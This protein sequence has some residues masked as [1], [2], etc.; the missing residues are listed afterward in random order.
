[1]IWINTTKE[2]CD[3]GIPTIPNQFTSL[4]KYGSFRSLTVTDSPREP[5][6]RVSQH[7]F[8][9]RTG[10][11]VA[12]AFTGSLHNISLLDLLLCPNTSHMVWV[13]CG[14]RVSQLSV[15]ILMSY[16]PASLSWQPRAGSDGRTN[17]LRHRRLSMD[18]PSRAGTWNPH[19][20]RWTV[21]PILSL[22][23]EQCWGS[24]AS[25]SYDMIT[26]R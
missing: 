14:R 25:L 24:P 23:C 9:L 12:T 2:A 4:H 13:R 8:G 11:S 3:P 26:V 10:E 1:M 17:P 18:S 15:Y 21:G 20:H 22:I 6:A 16:G 7:L 19:V 5:W